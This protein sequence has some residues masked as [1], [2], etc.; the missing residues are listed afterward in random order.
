MSKKQTT[1]T[2]QGYS[3][4]VIKPYHLKGERLIQSWENMEK[5]SILDLYKKPSSLK[6][7][8]WNNCVSMCKDFKGRAL[9]CGR[10][11]SHQFSAAFWI[12]VPKTQDNALVYRTKNHDYIVGF[13]D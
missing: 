13:F 11:S 5:T 7:S 4:L 6:K 1:I 9:R 10:K 2:I 3:F 8:A 12:T